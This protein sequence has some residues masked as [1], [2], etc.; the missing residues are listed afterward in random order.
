MARPVA[1][2]LLA[3]AVAVPFLLGA[4]TSATSGAEDGRIDFRFK[5]PAIVE[6][7]GLVV[8]GGRFVTV[9]DSG[10]SARVFTVDP[11]T[12]R[13]VG[14]TTWDAEPYDIEALAPAGPG[15]VWVGDIGDNQALRAS[16]TVTSVPV[17]IGHLLADPP[18]YE[19]VYPDGASDAETLLA[20][21]ETGRLYVVTKN[22]FG[23]IVY[24][25]PRRLDPDRPNRLAEVGS[26][27]GIATDG[28]FLPDGRH[29]VVRDYG[30][31][32]FYTFPGLE[33]V[34]E[35]RLPSQE[36]GEGIAAA[37]D[38]SLHVSSEGVES[39]VFRVD[40]PTALAAEV[41]PATAP[42]AAPPP[43]PPGTRAGT[44]L[45]EPAPAERPRWPWFLTGWLG[46]GVIVVLMWSLRRR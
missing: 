3:L 30:R 13:T 39:P 45:E 8:D 10:D 18:S 32:V 46:V 6:S 44:E 20:H 34:G 24:A 38:F 16:V 37:A 25:A 12:G 5:D 29:L 21:P 27:I 19:L 41:L 40:L 28:A 2:R 14:F 15:A 36:Q 26:A 23:G 35:V 9:N 33:Q 11:D 17:G 1:E 31:A 43:T 4:V 42:G 22:V 7:S